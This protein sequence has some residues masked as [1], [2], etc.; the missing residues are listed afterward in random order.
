MLSRRYDFSDNPNHATLLRGTTYYGGTLY[1]LHKRPLLRV[2][3]LIVALKGAPK[4]PCGLS[5]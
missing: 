4:S 5:P 3:A 2:G 1:G